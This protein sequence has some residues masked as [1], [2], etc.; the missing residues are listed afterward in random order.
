LGKLKKPEEIFDQVLWKETSLKVTLG[1]GQLIPG[2]EKELVDM[3]N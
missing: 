2:F 1:Q 3:E